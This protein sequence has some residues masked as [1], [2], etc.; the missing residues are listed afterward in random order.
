MSGSL[1]AKLL[2]GH[3]HPLSRTHINAPQRWIVG[4][5][6]A[7]L[8]ALGLPMT[9]GVSPAHALPC[10][11][12]PNDWS[13]LESSYNTATDGTVICLQPG[14]TYDAGS[15]RLVTPA[16]TSVT[17]DLN[18]Q[19]V[20]INS[21][22]SNLAGIEL[23]A[24]TSLTIIDTNGAADGTLTATG[25]AGT[26]FAGGGAG[27]GGNGG[28]S[29]IAGAAAGTLVVSQGTVSATGGAGNSVAGGGAGIGGGGGGSASAGGDGG[30]TTISD[31]EIIALGGQGATNGGGGGAGIG[32]GGGG[33]FPGLGG[34]GDALIASGGKVQA[35]GGE[36]GTAA[37]GGSA[38][39]SGGGASGATTMSA[40][41]SFEIHA[42]SS[43]N[44]APEVPDGKDPV[45]G[46]AGA[47]VTSAP[48][49]PTP[50]T[51]SF[52]SVATDPSHV[53][54]EFGPPMDVAPP[55][56]VSVGGNGSVFLTWETPTPTPA[57][58]VLGYRVEFKLS[59]EGES[60]WV[61]F[62]ADSDT[63]LQRLVTGLANGS[64]YDFRVAAIYDFGMGAFSEVRS[65]TPSAPG[66]SPDPDP[67]PTRD[68][69]GSPTANSGLPS[70][71][72]PGL[73]ALGFIGAF[74]LAG[75]AAIGA[76]AIRRNRP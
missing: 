29:G 49:A 52:T 38:V 36:A 66:P 31:G 74:A 17:I 72:G 34:I 50:R 42:V 4:A 20:T 69:S 67:D 51:W 76:G 65:A 3:M 57:L 45:R 43:A 62:G 55:N 18:G 16:A 39:G 75:G 22:G 54:L 37:G 40:G 6:A 19:D 11:A 8:L 48:L 10:D 30:S 71:G 23:A 63:D 68:P 27:I 53:V 28:P 73:G 15:S 21:P 47:T 32:G 25:G 35:T 44:P 7:A 1:L 24:G 14:G 70:T 59:S 41:G 9:L 13:S 46:G 56:L 60:Q 58:T 61:S 33:N 5:T 12:S 26:F 2:G 64:Q